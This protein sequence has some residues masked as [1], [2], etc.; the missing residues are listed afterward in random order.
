VKVARPSSRRMTA[1]PPSGR[2]C[3]W[4][5]ISQTEGL[6]S[7]TMPRGTYKSLLRSTDISRSIS[8]S[9][10]GFCMVTTTREG[11]ASWATTWGEANVHAVL[12]SQAGQDHPSHRL[13]KSALRPAL[14]PVLGHHAQNRHP[15]GLSAAKER[16]QTVIR[17]LHQPPS[18]A[19]SSGDLSQLAGPKCERHRL[20]WS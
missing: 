11:E 16:N 12:I 5:S 7:W 2:T 18:L 15:R 8:G 1:S 4:P 6:L 20:A 14:I 13:R 10:R 9:E 3:L 19:D 17:R